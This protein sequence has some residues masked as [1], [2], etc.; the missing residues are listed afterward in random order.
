MKAWWVSARAKDG[1]L[2]VSPSKL[3]AE[4]ILCTGPSSSL[5]LQC[6][7]L[8]KLSKTPERLQKRH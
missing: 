8:V 1:V 4:A 2:D 7:A 3:P 6:R 5:A